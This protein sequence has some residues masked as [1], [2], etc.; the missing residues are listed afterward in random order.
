MLAPI[1]PPSQLMLGLGIAFLAHLVLDH[2]LP[3]CSD[4]KTDLSIDHINMYMHPQ[5]IIVDG[6][7]TEEDFFLEAMRTKT[8]ALGNPLIELPKSASKHLAWMTKLDSASLA[9]WFF[10]VSPLEW[11]KYAVR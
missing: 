5:A 2:P 9:G 3:H 10:S 6:S 11:G 8:H 4:V 7:S 1:I